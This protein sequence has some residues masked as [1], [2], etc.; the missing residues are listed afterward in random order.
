TIFRLANTPSGAVMTLLS[1]EG[2][3]SHVARAGTEAVACTSDGRLKHNVKD[4]ATALE[5]LQDYRIRDYTVSGEAMFQTGVIA[6]EL[7][8]TRPQEVH[9]GSN[10]LLTVDQPNPWLLVK[11]IQELKADNDK[12]RGCLDSWKCRL[13]GQ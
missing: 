10:G 5:R 7:R 1:A 9:E 6:Q 2:S 3:C 8:E 12:L 4:T 11:A 13:F